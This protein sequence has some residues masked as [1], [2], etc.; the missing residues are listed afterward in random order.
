MLRRIEMLWIERVKKNK[1]VVKF[2]TPKNILRIYY[3]LPLHIPSQ[4]NDYNKSFSH[5]KY[6]IF[7]LPS[8]KKKKKE[9]EK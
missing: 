2:S 7:L 9:R 5:T 4:K 6:P 8:K 3:P 1:K